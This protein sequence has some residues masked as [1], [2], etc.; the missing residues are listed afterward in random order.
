MTTVEHGIIRFT[1]RQRQV[2]RL[3]A[4][5]CSNEEIAGQLGV[6]AR[7]AKAH[8][9]TLRTKLGVPRRRYIPVAYRSQTGED[10]LNLGG[11]ACEPENSGSLS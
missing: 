7:T 4:Q 6:T 2:V 11:T 9:D 8:C 1:E 5:G 10:P 3:L